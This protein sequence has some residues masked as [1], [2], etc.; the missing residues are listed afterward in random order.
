MIYLIETCKLVGIADII[1]DYVVLYVAI[2][3]NYNN[4]MAKKTRI[5]QAKW[6]KKNSLHELFIHSM[7]AIQCIFIFRQNSS[8]G[9]LEKQFTAKEKYI[10]WFEIQILWVR[11]CFLWKCHRF[12]IDFVYILLMQTR[13]KWE[14]KEKETHPNWHINNESNWTNRFSVRCIGAIWFFAL[15][16]WLLAC[17]WIWQTVVSI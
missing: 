16:K 14:R 6:Q 13:M 12:I 5:W 15:S 2:N 9:I 4:N 3:N 11:V 17:M 1:V 7:C 10:N 8:N